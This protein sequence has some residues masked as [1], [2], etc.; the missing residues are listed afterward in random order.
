MGGMGN[1]MRSAASPSISDHRSLLDPRSIATAGLDVVTSS[2]I[3]R[4][5]GSV[6]SRMKMRQIRHDK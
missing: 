6:T 2:S 5:L 4:H 3:A 1:G